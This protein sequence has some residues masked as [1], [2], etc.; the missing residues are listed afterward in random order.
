MNLGVRD[1]AAIGDDFSQVLI[2]HAY[3]NGANVGNTMTFGDIEDDPVIKTGFI[4]QL[5]SRAPQLD[6]VLRGY[7]DDRRR[8]AGTQRYRR[9]PCAIAPKSTPRTCTLNCKPTIPESPRKNVWFDLEEQLQHGGWIIG[10]DRIDIDVLSSDGTRPYFAFPDELV[11]LKADVGSLI[12]TL[13]PNSVI[14]I[15]TNQSIQ[16]AGLTEVHGAGSQAD[17]VTG[18]KLTVLEGGVVAGRDDNDVLTLDAGTTVSINPGGAVIAGARFDDG[19]AR[20]SPCK[21]EP[22]RTRS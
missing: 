12:E 10:E 4:P 1:F 22:V 5:E 18:T 17:L 11:S 15:H 14:D 19:T 2:G 7:D 21:R 8:R 6:Q 20:R 3:I 16:T 13:N 9:V